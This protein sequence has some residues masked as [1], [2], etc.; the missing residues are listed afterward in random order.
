MNRIMKKLSILLAVAIFV[1]SV[2]VQAL[3]Q[4]TSNP[5]PANNIVSTLEQPEAKIIREDTTKRDKF[6]KHFLKDDFT[7][8]AAV[9]PVAVHYKENGVWKDIDNSLIDSLNE[10]NTPVLENKG[11]SIKFKFSKNSSSNKLVTVKKDKY[12]LS[13]NL[14]DAVKSDAVVDSINSD[15]TDSTEKATKFNLKNLSS[16]LT[17]KGIQDGIDLQYIVFPEEIKENIILSKNPVNKSFTFELDAGKLD[18]KVNADGSVSFTDIKT[19]SEIFTFN[20]PYMADASGIRSEAIVVTLEKKNSKYLMTI[21]PDKAWLESPDRAYPVI[22]D[23]TVTTSSDPLSIYDTHVSLNFP[24]ATNYAADRLVVGNNNV[25]GGSGVNRAYIQFV[26][27][28]LT[29]ADMVINA[30]LNLYARSNS[31]TQQEIDAYKVTSSWD[32]KTINWN[33]KAPYDNS[34]IHDIQMVKNT[35]WYT[36]NITTIAK[37]WYTSEANN[38][39]VLKSN[40]E[41]I[42]GYNEFYSSDIDSSLEGV[43]PYLAISYVNASGLEDYWTYHS[44]D[45]GRAGTAY[46]NDYNGNFIFTH[47]DISMNGN[48]MPITLFHIFNNHEMARNEGYGNGWRLNMAQTIDK[49]TIG[50]VLYYVYT[51]GDGTKHY[52]DSATKK[53]QS[54]LDL[55]LIDNANGIY[56]IKDKDYNQYTFTPE[57]GSTSYYLSVIEDANHNLQS[58]YYNASRQ[59]IGVKDGAGRSITLGYNAA[60]GLLETLTDPSGRVTRYGYTGTTLDTITYPDGKQ[61]HYTYTPSGNMTS[62]VNHDGY[63]TAI[64]YYSSKPYRVSRLKETHTDGTLGQETNVS[65]GAHTGINTFTDAGGAAITYFFDNYGRTTS[66]VDNLGYVS[67]ASY[68]IGDK[69]SDKNK[70]LASTQ[71][72]QPVMNLAKNPGAES[73][74]ADWSTVVSGGS[75]GS[76]SISTAE[77]NTGK[78]SFAVAK[79]NNLGIHYYQ[80]HFSLQKGYNY[81][82]QAYVKTSGVTSG[83]NKGASLYVTYVD[84]DGNWTGQKSKII[85]GTQDWTKIGVGFSVENDITDVYVKLMLEGE[86]G[87]AY[88]DTVQVEQSDLGNTFN[89]IENGD[90]TY[91]LSGWVAENS[92]T[93]DGITTD[94][95]P[96]PLRLDNNVLKLYGSPLSLKKYN[97]L[98][99]EG[100]KAGDVLVL[101]GWANGN[102]VYNGGKSVY[103]LTLEFINADGSSVYNDVFFNKDTTGWQFASGIFVAPKDYTSLKAH[104]VYHYNGNPIM[105]DGIHL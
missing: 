41:S 20:T 54:G 42:F 16:S 96:H 49:V 2:P 58:V 71:M 81:A 64:E 76:T 77:K 78:K 29:S 10:S 3:N 6:V 48:R 26:L 11:N 35:G 14:V 39:I 38:G 27:P 43:R 99:P 57:N 40:N 45:T 101:G 59:V 32:R 37:G 67:M 95:D 8:E 66:I 92:G 51:D 19:S 75:T 70:L 94:T 52:F 47:N 56:I 85:S 9:Y 13:W 5:K 72:Q 46:V 83:N 22:I 88:F 69:T 12:K 97:Q 93:G 74:N 15:V 30:E 25:P 50:G 61:S 80:Q 24:T 63:K 68:G 21:T 53:D 62:A 65:Y 86:T 103:K 55:E 36:W 44:Y 104:L 90:F 28:Y 60:S 23:P 4:N 79:T 87:T 1:T 84:K 73:D 17:Y 82:V 33:N 34:V 102:A 100:G 31:S 89:L 18:G 105:F 7:Y 98:I 91:G